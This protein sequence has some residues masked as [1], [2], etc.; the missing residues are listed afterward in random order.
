MI[1]RAIAGNFGQSLGWFD[2][3]QILSADGR[4]IGIHSQALTGKIDSSKQL[5]IYSPENLIL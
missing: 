1:N 2:Q 3:S 4:N 5:P